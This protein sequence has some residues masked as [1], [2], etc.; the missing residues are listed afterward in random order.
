MR[1]SVIMPVYNAENTIESAIKS[2]IIQKSNDI[3]FIVVDGASTDRTISIINRYKNNIDYVISEKDRGYADALNKGISHAY[4]DYICMLAADDCFF[5]DAFENFL[6]SVKPETD[7]WCGGIILKKKYGYFYGYSDPDLAK[8]YKRCFLWHPAT[9]F[10]KD[11][12]SK[13]GGYD[14][15][16]KVVADWELFLRLYTNGVKFQVEKTLITL[17]NDGGLSSFNHQD[18]IIRVMKKYCKPNLKVTNLKTMLDNE[19]CHNSKKDR[20]KTILYRLGLLN[21]VYKLLKKDNTYLSPQE[22]KQIK[23][24]YHNIISGTSF[25]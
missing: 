24:V 21:I 17:F 15:S 20:L 16:Y 2:V 4:G 1:I 22:A 11:V 5:P 3:E 9:F 25:S 12:F 6:Q 10:N 13:F 23:E 18:E 14:I 19:Y 8:L 7:V